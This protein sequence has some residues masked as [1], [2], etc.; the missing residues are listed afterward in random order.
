MPKLL[1][2]SE[3]GR[4]VSTASPTG[5]NCLEFRR[6][7]LA[8]PGDLDR[9]FLHH[10]SECAAC[11]DFA[12]H[13]SQVDRR[14]AD[15]LRVDVPENLA[16]RIILRQSLHKGQ[17]RDKH[18]R[19]RYALAASVLLTLGLAGGF[20]T[21]IS[22][23]PF[24]RAVMAHLDGEWDSL[25]QRQDISDETLTSVLGT[26]GGELKG[27]IGKVRHASLCDFSEY[28]GAHLVL[29]GREGPVV[30][31]LLPGKHIAGPKVVSGDRADGI[32][33]PTNNGSM[34]IVGDEGEAL[35]DIERRLHAAVVWR[36]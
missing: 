15:A 8:E 21:M 23:T 29:E 36:L 35:D 34:V 30:V 33:V 20:F 26:V 27:D 17:V 7:C 9:E 18:R 2:R 24:H 10:K 14:L 11:A 32:I 13:M 6:R 16:S 1:S 19:R 31:L 4:Q 12:A 28:G 3:F 22:T 25:V 5:M